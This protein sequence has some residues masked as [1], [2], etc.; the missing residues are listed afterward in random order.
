LFLLVFSIMQY[1][2]EDTGESSWERPLIV[3]DNPPDEPVLDEPVPEVAAPTTTEAELTADEATGINGDEGKLQEGWSEQ[4][5]E[6]GERYYFNENTGESSWEKPSVQVDD[7]LVDASVPTSQTKYESAPT[8]DGWEAVKEAPVA[9]G[10]PDET[11]SLRALSMKPDTG[12]SPPP[13]VSELDG[14]MPVSVDLNEDIGTKEEDDDDE[15]IEETTPATGQETGELPPGWLE[16]TD[17]EGNIYFF[18]DLTGESSWERPQ[19]TIAS[20]EQAPETESIVD[21]AETESLRAMSIKR[22]VGSS[23]PPSVSELDEMVPNDVAVEREEAEVV[24]H[25]PSA[26]TDTNP[27]QSAA[28][29]PFEEEVV[30]LPEPWVELVT[31]AGEPYVSALRIIYALRC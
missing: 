16:C 14:M 29:E 7:A 2:N 9:D 28:E 8:S 1:F 10:A 19:G 20:D 17:P 23:P 11:E 21:E 18:N 30:A 25:G 31:D 3:A 4:T 15:I 12:S 22:D 5:T 13:S 27:E 6:D 26:E 24:E